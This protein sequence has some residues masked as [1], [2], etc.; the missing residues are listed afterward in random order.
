MF[1]LSWLCTYLTAIVRGWYDVILRH[2]L[3]SLTYEQIH[4][5]IMT[6]DLN[7]SIL[8]HTHTFSLSFFCLIWLFVLA[9]TEY[10]RVIVLNSCLNSNTELKIIVKSKVKVLIFGVNKSVRFSETIEITSFVKEVCFVTFLIIFLS[11]QPVTE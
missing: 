4:H 5:L 7:F 2:N 1:Y 6:D 10:G 8:S 11:W 3:R 9:L